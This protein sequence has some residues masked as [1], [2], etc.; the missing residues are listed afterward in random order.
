MRLCDERQRHWK[1]E[2]M[3]MIIALNVNGDEQLMIACDGWRSRPIRWVEKTVSR[4]NNTIRASTNTEE[5]K[6]CR[7]IVSSWLRIKCC[8]FYF[9]LILLHAFLL[10]SSGN[11]FEDFYEWKIGS[12]SINNKRKHKKV[13][14]RLNGRNRVQS[15][16][17]FFLSVG[18]SSFID[19]RTWIKSTIGFFLLEKKNIFNSTIWIARWN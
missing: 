1:A 13:L 12:S 15:L 10:C 18:S 17:R 16:E 8:K 9:L 4:K 14:S 5:E 6:S 11:R 19:A 7:K 2:G 3:T